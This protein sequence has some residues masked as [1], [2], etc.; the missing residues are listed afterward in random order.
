[1]NEEIFWGGKSKL[2]RVL[3]VSA[4][5]GS[6]FRVCAADLSARG[7][8]V[9]RISWDGGDAA[10]TPGR[11]RLLYARKY[12]TYASFIEKV[13][14]EKHIT[15]IITYNDIGERNR[16]ALDLAKRMGLARYI[17][18]QG[19]LRPHWVT[20]D[21]DGVNGN[22]NLPKS[23]GFYESNYSESRP[24]QTFPCRMRSQVLN[25]FG[26]FCT[27]LAL[28]PLIPFDTKYYGDSVF[29]QAAGYLSEYFWRKTHFEREKVAEIARRKN[30]GHKLYGVI[31]QKPGD[32]QLRI[33][34]RFGS[35]RP[36]LAELFESFAS[37][38]PQDAILVVKQHPLDY[39][40][41]RIPAMFE[42]MV[43]ECGL[44]GRAYYLRKTSFEIF[45]D[46]VT[47]LVTVNSTAGLAAV[48]RGMPVKCCG[49]AIYDMEGLTF[50]GSLDA[51]WNSSMAPDTLAVEK[52]VG[53][54]KSYSQV[55]GAI[56]A[57][58]GIK[59]A[60]NA[61]CNIIS[62]DF[63][64]PHCAQAAEEPEGILAP[65]VPLVPIAA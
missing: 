5:F 13:I 16:A 41:E 15:A 1:M 12:G 39:G 11:H 7:H 29:T 8:R 59:L 64:A 23:I 18:E 37:H 34:S 6:F 2:A 21:R 63:F 36:F 31:L 35:N 32:A 65:S 33:H 17:L 20:F 28:Y 51:F 52:F 45:L 22:A 27:S 60:S 40:I 25:T 53:Y 61:L 38:A 50:Q 42:A 48:Q 10:E 9:W 24:V 43:K 46:H 55:N 47:A 26:H 3:F 19:Y 44:G 54:L 58:K 4:P 30:L 57:P 49:N 56:Y 14:T 62:S